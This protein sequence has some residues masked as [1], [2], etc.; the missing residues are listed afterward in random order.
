MK[1]IILGAAFAGTMAAGAAEAGPVAR[2]CMAADR[3]AANRSLCTCIEKVARP[4][5]SRSEMKRIAS[6]FK[7]PDLSQKL[8]ASTRAADERF[9]EKYQIWSQRAGAQCS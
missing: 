7:N 8:R 3:S 2:A 4:M 5:F 6:L 9:W 1:K